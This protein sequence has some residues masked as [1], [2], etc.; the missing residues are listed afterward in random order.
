MSRTERIVLASLCALLALSAVML[1]RTF[2]LE[3]T[4]IIPREGGTYIEGAVGELQ[5]LNPWFITG[6]DVNRDLVSLI[7][8]GLMAY[9]PTTGTIIDDLATVTVSKDNRTYTATLRE[10]LRWHDDTPE[11]PHRVTSDDVMATFRVVQDPAFQNPLL[12]QNFR[13]VTITRIDERTVRFTLEKPYAF[14]RS[15][16]TLGIVPA[17]TIEGLP[18]K[19]LQDSLKDIGTTPIGA[20]RYALKHVIQTDL[21]TEVTLQRFEQP[22]LKSGHIDRMVIRLY[23][24]YASLLTDV[25]N[26]DGVRLA[27]RNDEGLPILPKHFRAIPYTLPQYVGLFFNLD[28][29]IPADLNVRLG[30]QRGTNK[31]EIVDAIHETHIVDTPLLEIDPGDWRYSFDIGAAQG[32]FYESQWN[33]PEKIRLQ[34]LLEEREANAVGPL[35]NVQSVVFLGT[36]AQLVLTGSTKDLS[37]PITINGIRAATGTILADGSVSALSGSWVVHLPTSSGMT[38]ALVPGRNIIRMLDRHGDI[39]DTAFLF[40]HIRRDEFRRATEENR[41]VDSFIASRSLPANDPKK[42]TIESLTYDQGYLRQR[43]TD[44]PMSIRRGPGDRPLAVTLLTSPVPAS[45]AKVASIVA[46]QWRKLGAMVTID[47]PATKKEFEEKLLRRDY[48]VVLFGQSLLDNLDSYPYWHSSQMQEKGDPTK[49]KLDAFNLS[50]Y[51]SFDVDLL[52]TR[53]REVGDGPTRNAALKRLQEYFSKDVPGIML[54]SPLYVTAIDD[55]RVHGLSI[56]ALSIHSDRL[57]SLDA[58]YVSTGRTFRPGR[59]WRHFPLWLIGRLD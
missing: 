55:N 8:R 27:L 39:V 53:I 49:L 52:L 47:L 19:D 32:A 44:D 50:Q 2:Y 9:D 3:Q 36:G 43:K 24:D 59:G 54:Y 45:Y 4:E 10:G 15:N 48:D 18:V 5:P 7:Y 38:G 6:T 46:A 40:R 42:T 11:S 14:F 30:L 35:H 16:L 23:A 28:R 20:G 51:A 57:R 12:Q 26:M 34:R 1:L 37:M 56:G 58:W 22:G 33:L 21:S 17:R 29:A 25:G 31:Q 13:G 41:L